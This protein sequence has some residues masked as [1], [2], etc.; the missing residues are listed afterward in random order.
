MKNDQLKSI[1][2]LLGLS[3]TVS[4][5]EQAENIL[6]FLF[7]PIDEGKAIPP[8]PEKMTMRTAKS[9]RT[10]PKVSVPLDDGDEYDEDFEVNFAPYEHK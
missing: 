3:S 6:N 5:G 9:P 2:D 1:S 10:T 4:H 7:E 8:P